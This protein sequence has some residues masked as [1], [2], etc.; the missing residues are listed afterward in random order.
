MDLLCRFVIALIVVPFAV[1]SSAFVFTPVRAGAQS[2]WIWVADVSKLPEDGTPVR[3][4]ALERHRDAW[5]WQPERNLGYVFL[6]RVPGTRNVVALSD[7][8]RYG[9]RIG[10][11]DAS[12][13][14]DDPCLIDWHFDLDGQCLPDPDRSG[15]LKLEVQIRDGSVYIVHKHWG[16]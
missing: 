6:R 16:D 9:T 10:Y 8:T 3:V 2:P 11:N 4:A 1:A 7:I 15:L 13:Q 5:T 14:F 12:R